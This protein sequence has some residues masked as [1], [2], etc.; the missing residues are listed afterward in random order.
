MAISCVL[1]WQNEEFVVNFRGPLVPLN[2]AHR[3]AGRKVKC[4]RDDVSLWGE[5]DVTTQDQLSSRVFFM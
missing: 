1:L 5:R 4:A 2:G 3:L